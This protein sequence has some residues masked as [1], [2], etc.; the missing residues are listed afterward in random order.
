MYAMTETVSGVSA[1]R[2]EDLMVLNRAFSGPFDAAQAARVLDLEIARTRRL[3]AALAA[4]GWLSRVRHGWYITVPLDA[5][6]P[7][8]WREDP[9]IVAA[10]LFA[11]CYIGGWSA[12]EHWGLTDQLFNVTYV[13]AAR[14]VT[15]TDQTIQGSRFRVRSVRSDPFF[16]TRR[17]WRRQTPVDLSDPHRTIVDIMDLPAAA[18]GAL[19]AAEVLRAYFESE[20]VD[21]DKLVEYGDRLGR[22]AMFKRL[23]YLVEHE[24]LGSARLVE[25][26]HLRISKGV[27][28]LDP[29]GPDVGKI[30]SRWNLKMNVPR[31][32]PTDER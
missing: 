3:L 20:H 28:R 10:T 8:D 16:G 6:V 4:G 23:G 19:H 11:P 1:A 30:V 18:G 17:V 29:D 31:L 22:G 32:A 14:K 21:E 5:A 25:A 24:Q 12:C 2:R 7:S 13:V 26:C 9:W 27:S 15:P